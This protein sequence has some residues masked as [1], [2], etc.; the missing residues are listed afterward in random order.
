MNKQQIEKMK[1]SAN[2]NGAII[3]DYT[4]RKND[5]IIV[6]VLCERENGN[7]HE[8]VVWI[9]NIEF[10]GFTNGYY[11]ENWHFAVEKYEQQKR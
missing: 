7:L 6:D 10:D 8:Y 11:T 5:N 2:K 1:N 4:K 3:L 9:Y